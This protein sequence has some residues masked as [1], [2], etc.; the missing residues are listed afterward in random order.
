MSAHDA[1]HDP[2]SQRATPEIL[3]L[4]D[5]FDV[6]QEIADGLRDE[7]Y[8]CTVVQR[9]EHA[10]RLIDS[11]PGRFVVLVSDI[12]MPGMDGLA[13]ARH[14]LLPDRL[15]RPGH[16]LMTGHAVPEDVATAF[17]A[18]AVRVIRKPFRWEEFMSCVTAAQAQGRSSGSD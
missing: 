14:L 6:A 2:H 17:P 3:I 18:G 7:G 9:A 5:E 1:A 4:D 12:R 10:L 8:R 15:L 11:Q 16:V 13:L